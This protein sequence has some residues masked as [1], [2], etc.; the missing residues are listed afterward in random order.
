MK[1]QTGRIEH[2]L[3]HFSSGL[4][5][6]FSL[7]LSKLPLLLEPFNFRLRP[8]STSKLDLILFFEEDS[9]SSPPL[10]LFSSSYLVRKPPYFRLF[11]FWS[12]I[13][14]RPL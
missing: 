6:I 7:F 8:E 5:N 9:L 4:Q 2:H 10:L 12:I 14:S 1:V 13:C 3:R 11:I